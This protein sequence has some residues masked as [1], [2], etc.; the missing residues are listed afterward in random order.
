MS[1]LL[2]NFAYNNQIFQ[3][4]IL[5][6]D[7]QQKFW[8]KANDVC[9]VLQYKRP[10]NAIA[11]NV[12]SD[13]KR[14][15]KDLEITKNIPVPSNWQP[16]TIFITELG[17]YSLILKSKM[18]DTQKIKKWIFEDS[19]PSIR[20]T[21][22]YNSNPTTFY[23]PEQMKILTGVVKKERQKMAIIPKNPKQRPIF[24]LLKHKTTIN[25]YYY[26]CRQAKSMEDAMKSKEDYNIV[27]D[28]PNI[29]NALI[30][31][32]ALKNYLKNN[33]I[34]HTLGRNIIRTEIDLVVII[35]K[36][37]DDHITLQDEYPALKYK[38]EFL[39]IKDEVNSLDE[40][41]KDLAII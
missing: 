11:N 27:F 17:V 33:K 15:W 29:A 10:N 21:R 3:I 13:E 5:F 6:D 39:A 16:K 7:K 8:V 32:H 19:L 37:K 34:P 26:I 12:E 30:F 38:D 20:K 24:R 31:T 35:L 9:N 4:Y 23:S 22:M 28:L 41:I 36:I 40:K 2:R 1:L 14:M 25:E 18:P